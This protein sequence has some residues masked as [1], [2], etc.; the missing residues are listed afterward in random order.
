VLV[1]VRAW[2]APL[3]DLHDFIV[4]MRTRLDPKCSLIV[5]PVGIDGEPATAEQR[6]TWSRWTA[7]IADPGLYLES[8][9]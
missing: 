4:M 5:V 3:L 1:F 8:G 2:E 9:A 6:A 7:R